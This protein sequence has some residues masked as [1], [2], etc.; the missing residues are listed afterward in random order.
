MYANSSNRG[1]Q[2]KINVVDG[3]VTEMRR[4]EKEQGKSGREG[5]GRTLMARK[6]SANELVD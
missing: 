6:G 3:P 5:K 1:M 4:G 2:T